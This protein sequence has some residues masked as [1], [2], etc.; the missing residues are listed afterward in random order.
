MLNGFSWDG[1]PKTINLY[2]LQVGEHYSVQ[3]FA[4]DNR[5]QG[6]GESIASPTIKTPPTR[7]NISAT[8]KMGDN[9]SVVGTFYAS[10][11][12]ET[13]QMNL[14]RATM[15]A[16]TPSSC[17]RCPSRQRPTADDHVEPGE[18]NWPLRDIRRNSP[19]R[20]TAT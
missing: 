14:R 3:I 2:N 20:R 6:G 12:T 17:V 13:I 7:A 18:Q 4:L 9:V 16:L 5:N 19:S 11:T 1:G 10:N 8:F 15:A